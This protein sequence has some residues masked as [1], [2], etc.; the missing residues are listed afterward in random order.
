MAAVKSAIAAL[1][2]VQ[3]QPRVP[4]RVVRMPLYSGFVVW[5]IARGS[6][7]TGVIGDRALIVTGAP[8]SAVV[9]RFVKTHAEV[10]ELVVVGDR[11]GEIVSACQEKV[12]AGS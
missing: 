3:G 1:E 9:V 10:D 4:T 11:A 6:S 8:L 7:R 12:R 5:S 2:I